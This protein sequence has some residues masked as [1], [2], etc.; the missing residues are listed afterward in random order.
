MQYSAED[1][2][3]WDLEQILDKSPLSALTADFARFKERF[4][5]MFENGTSGPVY[6]TDCEDERGGM[7]RLRAQTI[8][9]T[10]A[11]HHILPQVGY[12]RCK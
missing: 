2:E 4:V 10:K 6:N 12:E 3:M 11:E 1:I 5:K 8:S 7:P 9:T